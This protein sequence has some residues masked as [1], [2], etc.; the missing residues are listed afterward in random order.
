[1]ADAFAGE[2]HEVAVDQSLPAAADADAFD[3]VC[4]RRAHNG[5]DGRVH[6]GRV[7]AA[8]QNA[9]TLDFVHTGSPRFFLF[10]HG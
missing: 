7:A 9:D 2:R 1:M 3:A 10:F 5:A 8:G 6:A 4:Q